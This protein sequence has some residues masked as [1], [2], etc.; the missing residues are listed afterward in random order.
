VD[1]IASLQP[2]IQL[3][4]AAVVIV[5]YPQLGVKSIAD[6]IDAAKRRPGIAYASSGVGTQQHFVMEWIAQAAGIKL[7]HIPY[8]GAGQAVNDLLAGH[9]MLAA[10]GPAAVLPHHQA[11]TLS[12]IA[13]SSRTRAQVLPQIPTLEEAGLKGLVLETWQGAFAPERTPPA[14]IT[15]LNLEMRKAVLDSTI[16]QKLLQATFEPV[17]GSTEEFASLVREDSDKYARLARELKI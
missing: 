8:R 11:G 3:T 1:Y 7:D 9:V 10:A 4:R 15:R 16:E 6:L 5:V 14:I 2:I 12:I 17:G 13:Q